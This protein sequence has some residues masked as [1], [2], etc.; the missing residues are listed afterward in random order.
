MM[1]PQKKR[2]VLTSQT[3][4][5]CL[6]DIL[7]RRQLFYTID[8]VLRAGRFAVLFPDLIG[9]DDRSNPIPH[10]QNEHGD[11]LQSRTGN[12]QTG[13]DEEDSGQCKAGSSCSLAEI[14]AGVVCHAPSGTKSKHS[15][16]LAFGQNVS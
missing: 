15:V 7:T 13:D 2:I 6:S 5:S 16:P 11:A 1:T 4:K 14:P 9:N 8:W 3:K 10:S 12:Q